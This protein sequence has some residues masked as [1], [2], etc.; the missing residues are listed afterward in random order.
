MKNTFS[1]IIAVFD[2]DHTLINRDS[3]LPFLRHYFG[4]KRFLMNFIILVPSFI[5]FLLGGRSRQDIKECILK[6]F[7]KGISY[8]DVEK[9]GKEYAEKILDVF[10]KTKIIQKFQWHKR[11]GHCC[12]IV[13]AS[14]EFY[15]IPW[16]K[17]QGFDRVI[18]SKLELDADRKIT[19]RLNGINC[20][21][22]EK[23][24]RFLQ[25]FPRG[26]WDELYV[27]GDSQGDQ[28]LLKC[29]THPFYRSY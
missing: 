23:L 27:Y 16:G 17:R 9:E 21:G 15:V 7:F 12:I 22:D 28:A 5:L 13:S 8:D 20:W 11:Q 3:L 14:P 2:F 24:R 10:L 6:N 4:L 1:R 29:A 18:A 19:G 26:S 25:E